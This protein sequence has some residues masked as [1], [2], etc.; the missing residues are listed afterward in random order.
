VKILFPFFF[1]YS[2]NFNLFR[3]GKEII[4]FLIRKL[5]FLLVKVNNINDSDIHIISLQVMVK[6]KSGVCLPE[7]KYCP[8]RI[9][10]L[11]RMCWSRNDERPPFHIVREELLHVSVLFSTYL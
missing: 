4:I 1:F 7:P 8:D 5:S 11:M 3:D 10:E 2:L 6:I 9:Y